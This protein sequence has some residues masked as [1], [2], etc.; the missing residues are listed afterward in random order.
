VLNGP[1]PADAASSGVALP[2]EAI[3]TREDLLDDVVGARLAGLRGE[4]GGDCLAVELAQI[5]SG[6]AVAGADGRHFWTNW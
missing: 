3:P 2:P 4:A 6:L 1:T 5:V